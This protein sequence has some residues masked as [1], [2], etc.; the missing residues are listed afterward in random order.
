VLIH[1]AHSAAD[2]DFSAVVLDAEVVGDSALGAPD[3]INKDVSGS[4]TV[5]ISLPDSLDPERSCNF[6]RTLSRSL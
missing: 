4:P 6:R 3:S 5:G 1:P 2:V